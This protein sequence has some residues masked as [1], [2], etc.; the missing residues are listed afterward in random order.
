MATTNT[1]AGTQTWVAGLIVQRPTSGVVSPTEPALTTA[2]K[3]MQ[4]ILAAPFKWEWNRTSVATAFTTTAGQSDY[5]VSLPLFGYLET[6]TATYVTPPANVPPTWQLD[7]YKVITMDGKQ[8]R[9]Q[10]IATLLDDN[11]GNITFRI[12]PQPDQA[13]TVSLIY[14]RAP[15]VATTLAGTWA[16][17]PDKMAY[18]YE[19]GF[20][21][22]MHGIYNLPAYLQGMEL[23]YRML[24]S[25]SEGLTEAEK[26]IFLEESLRGLKTR[27]SELTAVQQGRQ[28]RL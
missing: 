1:I 2:N 14:Q 3:I 11:A 22:H 15:V 6:A 25:A 5:S 24:V 12:F 20:L 26:A 10:K 21:A 13:Y 27:A 16:P 8:N 18:L 9:P 19:Q 28:A 4:S 23:F 7:L 17:I